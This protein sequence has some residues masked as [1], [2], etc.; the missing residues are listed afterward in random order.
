MPIFEDLGAPGESENL[1]KPLT[2]ENLSEA[3]PHGRG[4]VLQSD[5]NLRRLIDAKGAGGHRALVV[6]LMHRLRLAVSLGNGAGSGACP[7][8]GSSA[9]VLKFIPG[10]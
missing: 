6:S 4:V 2:F 10:P 5:C 8:P 7:N 3:E 1:E 9:P